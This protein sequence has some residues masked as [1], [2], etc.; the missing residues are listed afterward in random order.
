M[1]DFEERKRKLLEQLQNGKQKKKVKS[2]EKTTSSTTAKA[3]AE[4]LK[5]RRISLGW[6][7]FSKVQKRYVAARLRNGGGTRKLNVAQ[8][9]TKEL[10]IDEGKELF[11]PSGKSS[12]GNASDMDFDLANFKGDSIEDELDDDGKSFTIQRYKE[13]NKLTQCRLYT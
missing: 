8:N 7:H 1:T 5:T 13:R 2:N 11:F 3:S 4:R 10:L 9:S 6:L 12:H